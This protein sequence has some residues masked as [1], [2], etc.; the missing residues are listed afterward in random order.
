M[1]EELI[2]L[3]LSQQD[4]S[5]IPPNKKKKRKEKIRNDH[6]SGEAT[7]DEVR[8]KVTVSLLSYLKTKSNRRTKSYFWAQGCRVMVTFIEADGS[9]YRLGWYNN[10]RRIALKRRYATPTWPDRFKITAEKETCS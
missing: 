7:A 2:S 4:L 5:F 6:Q 10:F 3:P 9:E 8:S 1:E